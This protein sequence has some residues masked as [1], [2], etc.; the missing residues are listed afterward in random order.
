MIKLYQTLLKFLVSI[1]RRP[2][3]QLKNNAKRRI[4]DGGPGE[5]RTHDKLLK[6]Q[7]LYH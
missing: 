7:L 1:F 6:R 4:F 2:H 3:S 5:N